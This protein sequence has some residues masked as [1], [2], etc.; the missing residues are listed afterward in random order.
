MPRLQRAAGGEVRQGARL[1]HARIRRVRRHGRADAEEATPFDH[2]GAERGPQVLK[3]VRPAPDGDQLRGVGVDLSARVGAQ[4]HVNAAVVVQVGATAPWRRY[5]YVGQPVEI[6]VDHRNSPPE[7]LEPRPGRGKYRDVVFVL[8]PHMPR[9]GNAPPPDDQHAPRRRTTRGLPPRRPYEQVIKPVEVQISTDHGVPCVGVRHGAGHGE[10][11]RRGGH[12]V[13]QGGGG[14][15]ILV[16]LNEL[17]VEYYGLRSREQSPG[18]LAGDQREGDPAR[19]VGCCADE[20]A[21]RPDVETGEDLPDLHMEGLFPLRALL[22]NGEAGIFP[23][24]QGKNLAPPSPRRRR[25]VQ[26]AEYKRPALSHP[27]CHVF[28]PTEKVGFK[29][30]RL[31]STLHAIV[32]I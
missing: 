25:L 6:D 31:K 19:R 9:C 13:T 22:A 32:V 27:Q 4:V 7:L 26:K 20:F 14:P 23:A 3:K 12:A 16:F 21:G 8:G 10:G 1:V 5:A 11:Q 28:H 24:L 30:P 15:L 2:H 29:E 18:H 17:L